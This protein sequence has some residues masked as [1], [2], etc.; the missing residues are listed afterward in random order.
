MIKDDPSLLSS[1]QPEVSSPT[2]TRPRVSIDIDT[3]FTLVDLRGTG[4]SQVLMDRY[5]NEQLEPSFGLI[6]GELDPVEGW[7]EYLMDP[8]GFPEWAHVLLIL[9]TKPGK[10]YDPATVKIAAGC[11]FEY[12]TLSNV[13]LVSYIVVDDKYLGMGLAKRMI[14]VAQTTV[15]VDARQRWE[16]RVPGSTG[17]L[18]ETNK[19]DGNTS[20]EMGTD[21]MNPCDRHVAL[22]ALGFWWLDLDYIQPRLHEDLPI[23]DNLLLIFRPNPDAHIREAA[24]AFLPK[25]KGGDGG[26]QDTPW[27]GHPATHPP[28]HVG[29]HLQHVHKLPGYFVG[30]WLKDYWE[31]LCGGDEDYFQRM[32]GTVGR[33]VEMKAL[34]WGRIGSTPY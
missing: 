26:F 33:S 1:L 5:H 30:G 14:N 27:T 11:S 22:H 4:Y 21:I 19:D 23:C 31:G 28:L 2:G 34:P 32:I 18:A 6:P 13:G 8:E 20:I 25:L 29:Q 16:G 3:R 7:H 10:P 15:D 24:L 17:L 9:D 12:S